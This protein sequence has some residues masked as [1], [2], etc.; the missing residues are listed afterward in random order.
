MKNLIV[1]GKCLLAASVIVC[2][3]SIAQAETYVCAM[4]LSH[5]GFVQETY[6]FERQVGY[7]LWHNQFTEEGFG[8]P[9]KF[10]IMKDDEHVLVLARAT[11]AGGASVVIIRKENT[12]SNSERQGAISFHGVEFGSVRPPMVGKCFPK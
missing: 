3:A 8:K 10:Q 1:N 12:S 6:R 5:A 11:F 9:S 7:F 4:T 2:C